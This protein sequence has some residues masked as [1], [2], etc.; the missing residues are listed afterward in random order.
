MS[1][2][3]S[4]SLQRKVFLNKSLQAFFSP[5]SLQEKMRKDLLAQNFQIKILQ[6]F[7]NPIFFHR[8]ICKHV[9][10]RNIFKEKCPSIL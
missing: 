9:F 4:E 8:E 6:V 1:L 3:H 2:N 5:I 7:F 10:A